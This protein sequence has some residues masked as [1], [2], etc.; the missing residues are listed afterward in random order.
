M[1][2]WWIVQVWFSKNTIKT[3]FLNHRHHGQNHGQNHGHHGR[4]HGDGGD[5]SHGGGGDG[6]AHNKD[7]GDGGMD[8]GDGGQRN[9]QNLLSRRAQLVLM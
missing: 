9:L 3:S 2:I 4:N 5:H 1:N 7:R 6:G 8:R